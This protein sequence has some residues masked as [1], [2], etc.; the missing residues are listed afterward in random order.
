M[1]PA[2]RDSGIYERCLPLQQVYPGVE[3]HANMLNALLNSVTVVDVSSSETDTHSVFS[4]FSQPE[5]VY[6][7]YKPDWEAG[8]LFFIIMVLGL[9]MALTF[10]FVGTAAMASTAVILLVAVTWL[11]FRLWT[12][13]MLDLGLALIVLVI[14]LV[15]LTNLIYG[16][17]AESQIRK[18]IK[19]MFDR[20]VLPAHIDSM[21]ESPDN[22]SFEGESKELTMLFSDIRSSTTIFEA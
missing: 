2:R 19:G 20:Y 11:N 3:V 17:L 13:Y 1:A 15:M 8:A 7:P 16:F 10:P 9:G 18:F 5:G 4:G 14:L 21:L 6:F 12:N 22:Y